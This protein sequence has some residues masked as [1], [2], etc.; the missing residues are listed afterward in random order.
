M[1]AQPGPGTRQGPTTFGNPRCLFGLGGLLAQVV[2]RHPAVEG[3]RCARSCG[4]KAISMGKGLPE[5]GSRG[6]V[7]K[8]EEVRRVVPT[9]A[10][11]TCHPLSVSPCSLP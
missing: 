8:L 6:R 2:L 5:V 11:F 3:C 7:R 10:N 1:R 9:Q 4:R